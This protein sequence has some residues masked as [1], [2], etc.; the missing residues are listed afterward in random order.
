M[1]APNISGLNILNDLKI[2]LDNYKGKYV[3]VDF[4]STSC[5]PCIKE[6]P[7]IKAV[8]DKFS[9]NDIEIIGIADIRGKKNAKNFLND[10]EVTWQ[11][12]EEK[13]PST[14]IKGYS[15]N[16]YPTSYLIDRN[17]KIIATDLR[18]EELNNKLEVLKLAKK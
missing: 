11:N 15:I 18:G 2:S 4:W 1:M 6:F 12:I 9:Q 17:G 16:S 5:V 10:K 13:N 3:F 14:N 7:K 8:Y